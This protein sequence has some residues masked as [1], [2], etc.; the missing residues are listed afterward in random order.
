MYN[1]LKEKGFCSN[2]FIKDEED[3]KAL[4]QIAGS[5]Q[6][7]YETATSYSFKRGGELV[8]TPPPVEEFPFFGIGKSW[9]R[10]KLNQDI[11]VFSGIPP[12]HTC[13]HATAGL[14]Q[15]SLDLFRITPPLFRFFCGF[16]GGK[17]ICEEQESENGRE[18]GENWKK[19]E[20]EIL[21]KKYRISYLIV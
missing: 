4:Q 17:K 12:Q 7:D 21:D 1:L 5:T 6:K 9:R 13:H 16:P 14:F 10:R 15:K 19:R 2:T 18:R 20:F 11:G 8:Q 3:R